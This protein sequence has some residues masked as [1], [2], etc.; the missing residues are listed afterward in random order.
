[1]CTDYT[2]LPH[3]SVCDGTPHCSDG[4]DEKACCKS[5]F[6]SWYE[7]L[8]PSNITVMLSRDRPQSLS[9]C[10]SYMTWTPLR[11]KWQRVKYIILIYFRQPG[12]ELDCECG[13]EWRV[14]N[15]QLY[16]VLRR[17]LEI[18][19]EWS[20]MCRPRVWLRFQYTSCSY[21]QSPITGINHYIRFIWT[22]CPSTKQLK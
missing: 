14:H 2:C 21:S 18:R 10:S 20:D 13:I 5:Y 6:L 4:A 8:I 7:I 3:T 22:I 15:K 16:G 17:S 12:W 1:M 19:L 11:R 9:F